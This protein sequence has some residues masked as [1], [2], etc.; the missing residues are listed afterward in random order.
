[1]RYRITYFL[2]HKI[3]NDCQGSALKIK[4]LPLIKGKMKKMVISRSI[5]KKNIFNKE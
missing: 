5:N 4:E 3:M 1:M 2:R